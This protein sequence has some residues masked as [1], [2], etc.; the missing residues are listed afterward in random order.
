[1]K[2]ER[3][4]YAALKA[5]EKGDNVLQSSLSCQLIP[6]F[7]GLLSQIKNPMLT[8]LK[9]PTVSENRVYEIA[10][11]AGE[12]QRNTDACMNLHQI[13]ISC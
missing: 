1:M 4:N 8:L 7:N 6:R 2:H 13:G 3:S 5:R 11:K 10:S 12:P 9:Q